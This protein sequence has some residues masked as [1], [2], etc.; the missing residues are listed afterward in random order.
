MSSNTNEKQNHQQQPQ[1][2]A[3]GVQK[4]DNLVS[5]ITMLAGYPG[6]SKVRF[7]L[8]FDNAS[9]FQ[10]SRKLSFDELSRPGCEPPLTKPVVQQTFSCE[11]AA[12]ISALGREKSSTRSS[13]PTPIKS[14]T[15]APFPL[16][17][18]LPPPPPSFPPT[19]P[20]RRT[21][22]HIAHLHQPVSPSFIVL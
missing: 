17:S 11:S 15:L 5:F 9:F 6:L 13:L 10:L 12:Q 8:P 21:R 3:K 22:F 4:L 19:P 16:R 1:W 7:R 2:E 14:S 20:F 18:L